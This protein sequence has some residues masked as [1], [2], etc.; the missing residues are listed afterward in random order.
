MDT[1]YGYR[2]QA[3]KTSG[4]HEDAD[5]DAGSDRWLLS[6][7]DLITTLMVFF[8]ALYVLQLAKTREVEIKSLGAHASHDRAAVATGG[9]DAVAGGRE[10]A[11]KDLLLRL[12]TTKDKR[13][14]TVKNDVQGVEIGIDARVL[15]NS[16]DARLLSQSSDVL[17]EIATILRKQT[18][19]NVLVEGHTDSVPI[20]NVRYASNWELSSARAGAVVRFLVDRGVEPRRL[21]AVG[22][23]D[24]FP[25]VV[26]DDPVAR[27]MNRRV[28][29][30]VQY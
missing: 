2:R 21:A 6:Y 28:T 4:Q 18:E 26:G 29:I 8:L 1:Q 11:R 19:S 13:Q 22:R 27:S 12:E 24:N 10:A 25:L 30:L 3:A 15:F 17:D 14:I 7:A 23:A 16:G 9:V 20:S 5:S